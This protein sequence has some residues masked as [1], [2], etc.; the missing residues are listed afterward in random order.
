MGQVPVKLGTFLQQCPEVWGPELEIRLRSWMSWHASQLTFLR[1]IPTVST[2]DQ[3]DRQ[4]EFRRNKIAFYFL[5]GVEHGQLRCRGGL[6]GQGAF[7]G[8]R[9]PP[10]PRS[11]GR[12]DILLPDSHWMIFV[13]PFPKDERVTSLRGRTPGPSFVLHSARLCRVRRLPITIRHRRAAF[14]SNGLVAV[15]GP[16]VACSRATCRV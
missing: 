10:H 16:G 1:P 9:A 14:G 11:P 2:A 12:L 13:F 15:Y 4:R 6:W 3:W 8:P 7:L 5:A